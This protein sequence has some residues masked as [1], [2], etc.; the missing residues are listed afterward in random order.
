MG[1]ARRQD[2]VPTSVNRLTRIPNHQADA[3][4]SRGAV[5][6]LADHTTERPEDRAACGPTFDPPREQV[7]LV[8]DPISGTADL[9]VGW[10]A[11]DRFCVL[12]VFG[13]RPCHNAG[14]GWEWLLRFED[15][16]MQDIDLGLP[17]GSLRQR[18]RRRIEPE[19]T[20]SVSPLPHAECDSQGEDQLFRVVDERKINGKIQFRIQ[21]K[22]QW[23][24][25]SALDDLE[26]ARENLAANE[27]ALYGD[28]ASAKP[29]KAA[30]NSFWKLYDWSKRT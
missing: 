13:V 16:W 27:A 20:R 19:M 6:E 26:W 11:D 9:L 4:K 17:E 2:F 25:K 30:K 14:H 3:G 23:L 24:A 18:L 12:G 8:G 21:W 29:T 22:L 7:S 5:R 10:P 28:E 1:A 15:S